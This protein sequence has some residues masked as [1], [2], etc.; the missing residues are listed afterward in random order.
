MRTK[1]LTLFLTLMSVLGVKAGNSIYIDD[2][3][4]LAGDIVTLSVQMTN[5][6][7]DKYCGFQFDVVLPEGM[8]FVNDGFYE[9]ALSTQRTT[10]NRTNFFDSALQSDGSL[11]I[12]CNTSASNSGAGHLYCF[13][14]TSGEVC[15]IKVKIDKN[16]EI[17]EHSIVL[18]NVLMSDYRATSLSVANST[19]KIEVTDNLPGII[20]LHTDNVQGKPGEK[21]TLSVQMDNEKPNTLCGFQFDVVLPEGVSFVRNDGFYET[22]LSTQRTT[23]QK[24]NFFDC[25]AQ[26][27]GSLRVLCNTT[28]KDNNTGRLYCFSGTSG[29]VCTVEIELGDNVSIGKHNIVLKNISLSDYSSVSHAVSDYTL[30]LDVHP[31]EVTSVSLNTTTLNLVEGDTENLTATVMPANATEKDVTWTTSNGNVATVD[32]QGKVTAV[33]EGTAIITVTSVNGKTAQCNVVVAKKPNPV[34]SITLSK[35]TLNITE[36]DSETLTVTYAPEDADDRSVTW[37]SS[38]TKIAT[39]DANGKVTAVAEGTAIITATSVNGKTAQCVVVAAKKPNPVTS[40]TLNKTTLNITEGDIETLTVT[41]APDDADD[42]SVTWTSSNG[43]V[44]TVD[45]NGKVTAIGVGTAIITATSVNGKTAQCSV[46]VAKRPNPVTAINLNKTTLNITEGNSETLTVTYAPE[47]ADDR[48]VTWITSNGNVA[49]VDAN[50]KVTAIGVGTAIITATS[51]NGKTAQCSVVVAKRPNPVTAITLNKSQLSLVEGD[52]ETL[53]VTYTPEDAD[54]RSVTWTSSDTKIATVDAN[55][56]VTAVAEGAAIITATS[57]NGRTA[58]C[59]VVV[60]RKP[61]PVTS[62]TLNK[63]TLNITEGDIETLTVTYAPEDADGRSV[64]WTSSDTKIATV[65]ANGKVTAI[66]VGTAIITATSA[67]GKTAQCSVAVAKRPNPVT[68]IT[69]NKTTLNITEGDSETLTVTYAPEDADDRSVTWTSSDTKIATVDASGKVTAVAEGTAIITA[70]SLN[71]KTAQCSVVVAKKPNPVTAIALNK[72]QLSLI[73][74]ENETLSVTYTP[75]DGDDRSVTWTSSNGNV[76]TV[77]ANGKV[78]AVA[79][80]TAIITATSVNGKTAQCSVV[81]AKRPNPVTAIA[82]NKSQLS[83]VEGGSETLTVTYA[84]EDA[85]GRSVTWTSSNGNVATVDAQGKVTAVAEG[86]AIITTTSVNGKTAQCVVVVARKPIPVTSISLNKTTLNITEGDS[87]TLIVTYAPEDADDRS[88]TWTSSDAKIVTVDANGK[89]TAVAEGAA[90]ITATSVNGKTAQCVV[91]VARKPNP[92]TSI[93]LSKT[94]LNI[95]EG[96]SETL[97]VTYA[98]EDAD[99]RSVTWTSSD[100]KIATVDA[101]GKITAVAEGA[102]IITATSVNGKTAQCIVVVAKK[103]NPVTSIT[104]NKTTLNITEGNSETLTVTYAPEDADDRTVTWTSSNEDIA[105]VD[106]EGNVTGIKTGSAVITATTSNGVSVKCTVTV[107]K[108][109]LLGDVNN[110]G[111]VTMADANMVVNYYLAAD[112]PED[113]DVETADVNGDGD[114]TMADANMIVNMYLGGE[115]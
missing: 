101:N 68:A 7:A 46:A 112:K 58:Q 91:I 92:V 83:L 115:K 32:A 26:S 84:P 61:N 64:S 16:I 51:V 23:A 53:T 90:I 70:T 99:D 81:V 76:A 60:G 19:S 111:S 40:I 89:V 57:L 96:D 27:D 75:A 39:V 63:T 98:P 35:T 82:L 45:A 25:A 79:E 110:D 77:D 38:D 21:I 44:A 17:G 93:T 6:E 31:I 97:T 43:N 13:S 49:T 65:D 86:T 29:E 11:R 71:G 69:L 102:A 88:V 109:V 41:Y 100:I 114:I 14:G 1:L 12:L 108:D 10:A 78:T 20:A 107:E 66:G 54:D 48:S 37:T 50:G 80:G 18:K 3:T 9:A 30:E 2:A 22:A 95:T 28:A 4:A 55:G 52:S 47:D 59:V 106:D 73:E 87:E 85:D 5:T 33:A 56:K 34:T 36:G 105:C 67:N 103:P 104:L 113:F 42:R 15:T 72:S 8:S 94:T 24:T 74:G 62:I